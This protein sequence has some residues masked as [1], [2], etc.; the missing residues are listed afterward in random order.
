MPGS[1]PPGPDEYHVANHVDA[2]VVTDIAAFVNGI[3]PRT[4]TVSCAARRARP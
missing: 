2:R 4:G 1:G 3:A